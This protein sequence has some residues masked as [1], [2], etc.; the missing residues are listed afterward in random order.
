MIHIFEDHIYAPF[1]FV[2]IC[3]IPKPSDKQKMRQEVIKNKIIQ[4]QVVGM[5][6]MSSAI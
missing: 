1:V 6:I 3:A 4:R 2:A 5:Y